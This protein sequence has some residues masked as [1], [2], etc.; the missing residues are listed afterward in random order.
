MAYERS[1]GLVFLK[2]VVDSTK[3]VLD[4]LVIIYEGDRKGLL[5]SIFKRRADMVDTLVIYHQKS[6]MIVVG[7]YD[8]K[9]AILGLE[10]SHIRRS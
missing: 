1:S 8:M 7:S 2:K 10:S 4:D 5:T 6:I 3:K 9:L